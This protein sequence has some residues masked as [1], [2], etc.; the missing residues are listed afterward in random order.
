MAACF[1]VL[2]VSGVSFSY[3]QTRA[4]EDVSFRVQPARVTMLLGPNGAGKTTLFSL[5]TKLLPVTAGRIELE[6]HDLGDAD[7]DI[8]ERIGIVFQ[9]S[10]LDLDLTVEQNLSYSAAL[11]GLSAQEA[12]KRMKAV[13]PRLGLG[14]HLQARA[15]RLNDGH[16]RRIEIA[17]ALIRQPK[18]LLLDE[19]TTGLDMPTRR[20]LVDYL[21]RMAP[22]SGV[23]I[24]WATHLSDEVKPEDDLVVLCGGRVMAQGKVDEVARNRTIEALFADLTAKTA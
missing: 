5:I 9:Q 14:E 3:G 2:A 17:R 19:P 20:A 4:L 22:E 8:L 12:S 21:H 6:G 23:A 16:R 18:L 15:R 13:L 10:T 11:C 1:P 24:L 7:Y